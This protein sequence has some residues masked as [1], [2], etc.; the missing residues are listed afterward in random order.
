MKWK[1]GGTIPRIC[2]GSAL[3][4]APKVDRFGG[5]SVYSGNEGVCVD[6][7]SAYRLI[8]NGHQWT[9][10]SIVDKKAQQ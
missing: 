3:I 7:V 9:Q 10:N 4:L 5:I 1:R 6:F 8:S 2:H